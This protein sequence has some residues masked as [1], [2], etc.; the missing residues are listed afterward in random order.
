MSAPL[1]AGAAWDIA[2][3]LLPSGCELELRVS[4]RDTSV[5][6]REAILRGRGE[7]RRI[8][9]SDEEGLRGSIS[10]FAIDLSGRSR[11]EPFLTA[12]GVDVGTDVEAIGRWGVE[13]LELAFLY[14]PERAGGPDRQY[15]EWKSIEL[16]AKG[17]RRAALH[18]C[19]TLAREQLMAGDIDVSNFGRIQV[20]GWVLA[21]EVQAIAEA[22]G[23]HAII[24]QH[25]PGRTDPHLLASWRLP[26]VELLVDGSSGK[27]VLPARWVPPGSHPAMRA[28]YAGGL[29][30]ENMEREV[31][32]IRSVARPGWWVDMQAGLRD[33]GWFSA[34]RL[35]WA[36]RAFSRAL[37]AS[38]LC[39]DCGAGY[40][41][42]WT[43]CTCGAG[44][45]TPA[46]QP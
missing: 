42:Y 32:R 3:D 13:D 24:A 28:G 17:V 11:R 29:T 45:A 16:A 30:R 35:M 18:L 43:S 44:A 8:R 7:A 33:D 22:Y 21:T 40:K 37:E 12:T 26:N 14:W 4:K 41:T 31:R 19:G 10:E 34:E 25:C 46:D 5:S 27:G 36:H 6:G 15:P 39:Q 38:P 2:C 9:L 20:N 1:T 23:G